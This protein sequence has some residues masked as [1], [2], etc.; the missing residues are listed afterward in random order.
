ME[1]I[2][3]PS[4]GINL[5]LG[6]KTVPRRLHI[7]QVVIKLKGLTALIFISQLRLHKKFNLIMVFFFLK[8]CTILLEWWCNQIILNSLSLFFRQDWMSFWNKTIKKH[9]S[10][11][12][13][14]HK[15]IWMQLA[16]MAQENRFL[17]EWTIVRN[18]KLTVRWMQHIYNIGTDIR[19]HATYL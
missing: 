4:S 10:P 19:N 13:A 12:K 14:H 5:F 6:M 15:K 8:M 17:L 7:Y 9:F 11:H 2:C 16:V 1:L 3:S 18:K